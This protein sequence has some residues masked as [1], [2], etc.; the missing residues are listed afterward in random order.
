M[1]L[2]T[3]SHYTTVVNFY[4]DPTGS[5]TLGKKHY[6]ILDEFRAPCIGMLYLGVT[7]LSSLDLSEEVKFYIL[8]A[9]KIS[10]LLFLVVLAYYMLDSRGTYAIYILIMTNLYKYL[11]TFVVV[12]CSGNPKIFFNIDRVQS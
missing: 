8:H 2:V 1:L 10:E 11:H 4:T 3:P 9:A 5:K 6:L 12:A 7:S